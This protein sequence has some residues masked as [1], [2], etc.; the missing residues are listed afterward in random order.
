METEKEDEEEDEKDEPYPE[1]QEARDKRNFLN[2]I[3]MYSR[4]EMRMRERDSG[5]EVAAS[6]ADCEDY[7]SAPAEDPAEANRPW[8]FHAVP[9]DPQCHICGTTTAFCCRLCK[10][11]APA[12]RGAIAGLAS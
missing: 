9:E 1:E 12:V 11:T 2:A 7:T 4:R 6:I 3:C 5:R 8:K 10:D